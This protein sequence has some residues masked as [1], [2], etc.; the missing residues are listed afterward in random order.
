MIRIVTISLSALL[1][2]LCG[3]FLLRPPM[4]ARYLFEQMET[5][6]VGRTTFEDAQRLATK[7]GVKPGGSCDR[8]EC[9]WRIDV[10]NAKLPEWWRGTGVT[11]DVGFDVKDGVVKYKGAW[12][13]IGID[14]DNFRPASVSAGIK[15][16]W[17]D[18]RAGDRTFVEP[19]IDRGGNVSYFE[20]NGRRE[21]IA[22]THNVQ[23]TLVASAEEWRRYTA[24]NYRCFWKYKG[25]KGAK[26]LLSTVAL[27]PE[28]K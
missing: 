16:S 8:G 18:R 15:E 23:M 3:A 7:L 25:C 12:Y 19:P 27:L 4:R 20:R 6:E 1:L 26:D 17:I 28:E 9:Q 14:T 24:F 5:L 22:F 13:A 10:D 2:L 11:F 21:N